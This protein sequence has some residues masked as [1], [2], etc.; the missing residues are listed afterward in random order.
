[1]T[2]MVIAEVKVPTSERTADTTK[3]SESLIADPVFSVNDVSARHDDD[4][5]PERLML[6][7]IDGSASRLN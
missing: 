6:N 5:I 4:S 3:E 1:M 7:D 2:S